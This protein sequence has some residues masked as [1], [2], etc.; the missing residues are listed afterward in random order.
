MGSK[1]V[2]SIVAAAKELDSSGLPILVVAVAG[3][4]AGIYGQLKKTRWRIPAFIYDF[5]TEMPL[6]L[7]AADCVLSKSSIVERAWSL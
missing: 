3:G 6:F 4:D 2:T 7:R 1:R 5:V